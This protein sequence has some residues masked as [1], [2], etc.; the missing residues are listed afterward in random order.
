M[1][2]LTIKAD[3]CS[4]YS[5]LAEPLLQASRA[6]DAYQ[7]TDPSPQDINNVLKYVTYYRS[8]Y[9]AVT[10]APINLINSLSPA[11]KAYIKQLQAIAKIF[12]TIPENR[13]GSSRLSMAGNCFYQ[14]IIRLTK[15]QVRDTMRTICIPK[16]DTISY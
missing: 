5:H 7:A 14:K 12:E 8:W 3:E 4:I 13:P 2:T 11:A 15:H 6:F 1:L 16:F 9:Q 10:P